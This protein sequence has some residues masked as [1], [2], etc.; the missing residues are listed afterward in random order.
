MRFSLDQALP[1]SID[2]VLAAFTDPGY[3]ASLGELGK[4]GAPEVLD[5]TQEGDIVLQ[6]VRYHFTGDLSPA[7]TSV[8]DRDKFVW[9]DE[10]TYDLAASSASFQIV[11]EHYR[12]RLKCSGTERFH[13]I[14]EGTNRHVE[15]DLKV[16]WPL[17]GGLV[18]RAIVSGL[19]EHL[20]EEAELIEAWLTRS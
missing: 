18:E 2:E 1:G 12:D 13:R 19:K 15:A 17:V 3:L 5:Q 11:P 14:A 16:K 6:R 9:V 7:V 10:H 8:I 4:V 20:A